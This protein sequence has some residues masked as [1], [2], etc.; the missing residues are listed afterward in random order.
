MADLERLKGMLGEGSIC[1]DGGIVRELRM[2][3]SEAEVSKIETACA[4]TSRAFDRVPEIARAG[5]PL[6]QVFREF[7][8]LCLQEGADWLPYVAGGAEQGGYLDVISPA[9]PA[10]LRAGDVLMLDAGVMYDGYFCDFDRNWSV[11]EP[12]AAVSSTH[13][14]LIEASDAAAELARPGITAADLFHTM[15]AVLSKG[16]FATDSG[17]LGHG[18]GM[19][20]TEWPSL[21]PQ[22][23]TVLRPGMVLT[24]E[25]SAVV[26]DKMMVHEEN[27]LITD[28]GARFLS[29]RIGSQISVI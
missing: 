6:E 8:S 27:I 21:I 7:Q 10:P 26:G 19:S 18:L 22:D 29:P 4:I 28:S 5:I 25:P 3:K 12:N 14:R 20:L 13:A 9:T 1:G 17:R 15:E 11:D 23:F 16:D 2:I 24:L